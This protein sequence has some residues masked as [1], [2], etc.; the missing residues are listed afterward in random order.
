M[1]PGVSARGSE[2]SNASRA[3]GGTHN[4]AMEQGDRRTARLAALEAHRRSAEDAT[5]D[6][7]PAFRLGT[8]AH[9]LAMEVLDESAG[10]YANALRILE[11]RGDRGEAWERA[12]AMV[13]LVRAAMGRTRGARALAVALV[14][15]KPDGPSGL[16]ALADVLYREGKD[17]DARA[18]LERAEAIAPDHPL[19]AGI[20]AQ[21]GGAAAER[22]TAS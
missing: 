5:E 8:F 20:R 19:V 18:V 2:P 22:G 4:G 21:R 11:A 15:E 14:S 7:A 12:C 1:G 16:A 13:A 6:P 9:G 17:E 3:G 10:A